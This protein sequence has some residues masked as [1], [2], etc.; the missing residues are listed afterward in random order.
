MNSKIYLE[1]IKGLGREIK[2]LKGD[3]E[4]LAGQIDVMKREIQILRGEKFEDLEFYSFVA[5]HTGR[6]KG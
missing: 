3:N 1:K 5:I 2:K 6:G 4:K